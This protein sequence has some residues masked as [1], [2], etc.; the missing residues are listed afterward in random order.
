MNF[1]SP[2]S[3]YDGFH[4]VEGF[5]V[6]NHRLFLVFCIRNIFSGYCGHCCINP[7]F[8]RES[9]KE[10]LRGMIF[11]REKGLFWGGGFGRAGK[12]TIPWVPE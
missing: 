7:V 4:P 8:M 2:L 10:L 11:L 12:G 3:F 5:Q 6:N 9:L 1:A